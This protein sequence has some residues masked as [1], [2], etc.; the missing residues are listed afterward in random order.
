MGLELR[1][2]P[3]VKLPM[4]R[5]SSALI[6]TQ[7]PATD[8]PDSPTPDTLSDTHVQA[9]RRAAL[10]RGDRRR[11]RHWLSA[12]PSRPFELRLDTPQAP[13]W[14]AT[15][16]LAL[17]DT[18]PVPP[19]V[20]RGSIHPDVNPDHLARLFVHP[21]L[22]QLK[23]DEPDLTEPQ[24]QC[25]AMALA[26]RPSSLTDLDWADDG[27]GLLT[28]EAACVLA[29][30]GALKE[31]S[32]RMSSTDELDVSRMTV[33]TRQLAR[34]LLGMPLDRLRLQGLGC[35]MAA[36]SLQWAPGRSAQ[37]DTLHI[38][39]VDLG[40][41]EASFLLPLATVLMRGLASDG[42]TTLC[43]SGFYV[44]LSDTRTPTSPPHCAA[45]VTALV[46]ALALGVQNRAAPLDL[47]VEG[48][49]LGAL[50][51]LMNGLTGDQ[52]IDD[53]TPQTV[54]CVRRLSVG[55]R[56]DIEEPTDMEWMDDALQGIALWVDAFPGLQALEITLEPQPGVPAPLSGLELTTQAHTRS[57]LV[58]ALDGSHVTELV[59]G[60]TLLQ[61][62]PPFLRPCLAR[63]AHRAMD[64]SLRIQALDAP[65]ALLHGRLYIPLEVGEQIADG[66]LNDH[67]GPHPV[68]VLPALS[69]QHLARHVER[70]H[71]LADNHLRV[72]A[73]LAPLV[74][75]LS[76]LVAEV[77][78]RLQ[79]AAGQPPVAGLR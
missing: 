77:R 69:S 51:T 14:L 30:L 12:A 21:G 4:K 19:L 48:Q 76:D 16:V 15:L 64:L 66:C 43:L 9:Q 59:L 31:L 54:A 71:Q 58:Q 65:T 73:G 1:G 78:E 60:G 56:P 55:Y 50:M 42:V 3:F 52:D 67:T 17:P 29:G 13:A 32:L 8:R 35:F 25:I 33:G 49:D 7:P 34:T 45:N 41:Q 20:L 37:W 53:D 72:S 75:P 62:T 70:Y 36:L 26:H 2:L 10:D 24:L 6:P 79:A 5:T 27:E 63:V 39:E 18:G 46:R 47:V 44:G 68:A 28:T 57:A 61:P 40:E 11:L 23:L 38:A 74:H 22:C